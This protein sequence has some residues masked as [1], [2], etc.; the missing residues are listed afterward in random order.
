[1]SYI[2]CIETATKVCS[3]AVVNDG[4]VVALR[5]DGPDAYSHAEKL[6]AFIQDALDQTEIEFAQLD[7]IAVCKGP[8]SYTG[9]RIGTSAAKGLAYA[10]DLPLLAVSTLEALATRVA[11]QRKDTL[12][13]PMIDARRMEVFCAGFD[14]TGREVFGTRAEILSE[15]SFPEADNFSRVIA[16]GDGADKAENWAEEKGF[17]L[18]KNHTASAKDMAGLATALYRAG[19]TVDTAYFEPYYLKD[20]VAGKKKKKA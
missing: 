12:I 7:A 20:F 14:G 5:E 11:D 8:G 13:L 1:M 9:L 10:L 3:V 15:H 16:L 4:E 19:T 2:L 6:N 18:Q 17:E